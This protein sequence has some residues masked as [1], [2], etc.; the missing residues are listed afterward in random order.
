MQPHSPD[1][2]ITEI[3]YNPPEGGDYEF[4][5]L[6]NRTGSAVT[7]MSTANT[8]TSPT[9]YITESIPWR[10]EGT[11]YE[12]PG[13]T[14]IPAYSHIIVAKDPSIYGGPSSTVLGPYDGQL[15]N[16]GE[17]IELQIPGDWEYGQPN[18]YWIPIEKIDYDD[19]APWPTSP[20]GAGDSLQR[21]NTAAY[22]RDYSN[23]SALMPTPGS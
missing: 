4:V 16:G 9:E 20:D 3:H 11:G 15:S 5:E 19:E 23:W 14:T 10:L 1:V 6:Y 7:L 12:F 22:G 17:Q 18:R 2:V 21:Q 13:S 8:Y